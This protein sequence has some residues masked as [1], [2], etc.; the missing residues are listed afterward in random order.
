[1]KKFHILVLVFIV[2][3]ST[4][5]AQRKYV[6]WSSGYLPNYANFPVSKINW[7]CYTHV[8][9]FSINPNSSGVVGGLNATTAKSFT[10]ACHQNNAKAIICVG[11]A[12]AANGFETA[13]AN[14][15]ILNT[16][17]NSMVSFM[18]S[19]GF[20]GIDIDWEDDG[21]GITASR[22]LALF[23]GLNTALLKITPK[24][25]LTAAVADYYS[26]VSAP[27]YPYVDQ[28]NIMSYYDLVGSS[29]QEVA[30]F[31]GKGVP[32]SK[33]GIGYGYD[34]DNEVDGPNEAGNGPNG[35]P[36][37]INAKCLYSINNGCG[38]IMIWSIDR[39]PTV[40]DS[41]TAYYVNKTVTQAGP[42]IPLC[43]LHRGQRVAFTIV[44]NG[45]TGISE[46]RYSVPSAVSVK[47]ALFNMKGALVQK[48]ASGQREP[49]TNYTVV[50]SK[51]ISGN[52]VKPGAYV[53]K[54]ATPESS[55]Q[56]TIIIK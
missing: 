54:L 28:M 30:A 40:C 23:Q 47:L 5:F 12:G 43:A 55:E 25:L 3:C 8:F 31:T 51:N 32:K 33:L 50:V 46:I 56:G 11:G 39:A 16:F 6:G 37:D 14:S 13:T 26:T 24:P 41:V 4:A 10:A 7:K 34:T 36:T 21:N 17:V 2:M 9:W 44:N 18:Q 35:N 20:D 42:L 27:V 38:G 29:P 22:Y 45:S 49:G 52:S 1:M 19:N 48:L 15:A 53:V